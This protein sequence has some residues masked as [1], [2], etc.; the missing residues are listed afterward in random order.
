M[1]VLTKTEQPAPET[2]I[3]K[4]V[5]TARRAKDTAAKGVEKVR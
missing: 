1:A 2:R 3:E 4:L 5:K